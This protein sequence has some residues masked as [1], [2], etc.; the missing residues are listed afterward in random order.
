MGARKF[1]ATT[2]AVM[3][4]KILVGDLPTREATPETNI[5]LETARCRCGDLIARM[6]S[7]RWL[8]GRPGGWSMYCR[9]PWV[10]S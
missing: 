2:K 10:E 3:I 1:Q 6:I 5:S 4:M 8:H 9:K 7:G